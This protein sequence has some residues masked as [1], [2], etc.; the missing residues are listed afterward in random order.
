[1]S[2]WKAREHDHVVE[3]IF[4]GLGAAREAP[5]HS[6]AQRRLWIAVALVGA[7]LVLRLWTLR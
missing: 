5:E 4:D 1:V 6:G 2:D 7:A 3:P